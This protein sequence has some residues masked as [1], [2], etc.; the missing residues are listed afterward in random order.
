MTTTTVICPRAERLSALADDCGW[1]AEVLYGTADEGPICDLMMR[2]HWTDPDVLIGW[3][4][5]VALRW[6]NIGTGWRLGYLEG[7]KNKPVGGVAERY[8]GGRAFEFWLSSL[9]YLEEVMVDP[10]PLVEWFD[11]VAPR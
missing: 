5:G 11:E 2:S 4:W 10:A 6:Y 7:K 3:T 9:R 8:E 1:D